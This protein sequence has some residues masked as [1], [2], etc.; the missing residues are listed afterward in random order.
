MLIGRK[1]SGPRLLLYGV[2]QDLVLSS[3]LFNI[4]MRPLCEMIHWFGVRY[5]YT[6]DTQYYIST[7]SSLTDAVDILSQHLDAMIFGPS[8]DKI[9]SSLVLDV[10]HY[11]R[12]GAQ[13]GG[14]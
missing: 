2:L 5:Q 4:Y 10:W 7:P 8:R 14:P 9:L 6:D 13:S 11:S 12:Q 3:F 1:R